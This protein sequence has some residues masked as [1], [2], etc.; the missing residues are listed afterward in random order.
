MKQNEENRKEMRDLIHFNDAYRN[1]I[2][3]WVRRFRGSQIKAAAKV[4]SELLRFY[5]ALGEDI[6]TKQLEQQYGDGVIDAISR[7]LTAALP[8][9]QGFSRRNLYYIKNFYLLY[10][11]KIKN[12]PQAVAQT[13]LEMIFSV[14]WGHHRII[15][16]KL[17]NCP[18]KALFFLKKTIENGWSRTLLVNFIGTNLYERNGKAITNF[19][20]A[21]PDSESEYAKEVLNNPYN[22]DFLS[23]QENFKERDLQKALEDNISRFL[24]ELGRGFAYV[25]RQVRLDVG[26]D[27]FFCDLLFY[28]LKLRRYVVC[29][30][31]TVK[32]EPEF[33]GKLNFYCTAVNHLFKGDYDN[34]TIG[35]LICKERNDLVAQ[36]TLE[37]N[38]KQPI[39]ISGYDFT[40][41]L[42]KTIQ[43]TLP[44]VEDIEKELKSKA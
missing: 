23:L 12:V 26:N 14:P 7:D 1:W 37:N 11:Q 8:G 16:D 29:E 30:L 20:T 27:E 6:V 36:W 5:W 4:N 22:F 24:L 31:K 44:S 9:V 33:V 17:R 43:D 21:L 40:K 28:H 34:D 42:P 15:I 41:G 13:E 2:E 39:G 3:Q 38:Q 25:G 10:N 32:F 19:D 18:E 35:L